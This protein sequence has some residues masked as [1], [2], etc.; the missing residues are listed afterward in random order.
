MVP[1][2][3]LILWT[4]VFRSSVPLLVLTF[5]IVAFWEEKM[6]RGEIMT[7]LQEKCRARYALLI[8]SAG[9]GLFHIIGGWNNDPFQQTLMGLVF[10]ALFLLTDSLWAAMGLHFI[11]NLLIDF[12]EGNADYD[13][14]VSPFHLSGKE[15]YVIQLFPLK[16]SGGTFG[17]IFS[18]LLEPLLFTAAML[19]YWKIKN[20]RAIQSTKVDKCQIIVQRRI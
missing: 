9:F 5:A 10:G 2:N 15:S 4:S 19:L 11:H 1:G 3:L 6:W 16:I 12:R 14:P 20:K 18:L 8:S 17:Y 13:I 7:T